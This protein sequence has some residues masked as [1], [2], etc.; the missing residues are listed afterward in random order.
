MFVNVMA[1]IVGDAVSPAVFSIGIT[2]EL[3]IVNLMGVNMS[4]LVQEIVAT[5]MVLSLI[6]LSIIGAVGTGGGVWVDQSAVVSFDLVGCTL[7]DSS[8]VLALYQYEKSV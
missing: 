1:E 7:V 3:V 4:T 8:G 5:F 2:I 6:A